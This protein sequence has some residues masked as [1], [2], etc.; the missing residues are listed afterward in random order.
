MINNTSLANFTNQYQLSKTLRFELKPV[1]RTAEWIEKHDIIGVKGDKLTGKDAKKAEHYKYAKRMLDAMHRIFIEDALGLIADEKL[2]NQLKNKFTELQ[3]QEEIKIDKDLQNIFKDILDVTANRW[4]AEYQQE[5][6]QFWREDIAEL[7]KKL[8]VEKDNQ[9]KKGFQSAIKAVQKKIDASDKVIK[10]NNIEVMYSNEDALTLLEWK[11]RSGVVQVTFKELE[12]A[13][14]NNPIPAYILCEYLRTFNKFYT[15]FAGFNENRQ[16]V[17]DLSGEKSTSIINR[18]IKDNLAFHF[19]NLKKWQTIRQSLAAAA[20]TFALKSFDPQ[21]LLTEIETNLNFSAESFFSIETFCESMNQSGIDCYNEIIGGRP[22]LDGGEKIQGI[23]EFINLCRQQADGK[24]QQFPPMQTLYKQILSKSDRTFIPEFSDDRDMLQAIENFHSYYFVKRD[25]HGQN[26]FTKFIDE[27]KQ[28]AT[29][30]AGEY[31]TIFLPADKISLISKLL[32]GHWNNLNE[33]LLEILGETDFNKRKVFSFAEIQEALD[34]GS[35]GE[36]FAIDEKFSK[37]NLIDCLALRFNEMSNAANAAWTELNNSGVLQLNKL[38]ANR[39]T[40]GDKGFEQIAAIKTFLDAA[41]ELAGF[42]RDWQ[43]NKE[44]LKMENRNRVWYNHIDDFVNKFQVIGVYNMVRNHITKKTATAEKLKINFENA[45]LLDGWDRNKEADNYGILLEKDNLFYL[46]IMTADSNR[47]FDYA[48]ITD[49]SAKK[50]EEKRERRKSLLASGNENSY[51]KMNYKQ[52]ASVGKDIFTLCWDNATNTAIRKTKDRESVWGEEI[53]RIKESKSYQNNESDRLTYFSYLLKCAQ[54]YWKHFNLDLKAAEGYDSLSDLL[55]NIANQ[56]YSISF[57]NVKKTYID[58]KVAT[59]ELYLFQIYSKDF[60]ATKKSGGRDNLH[61]IYWKALFAPENLEKTV[62]KLNGQA[63]IFFRQASIKYDA[64]IIR[65]GHHAE[66]LKGKFNYPIIKN[67]RFTENKFFF[68]CPIKLNFNAPNVPGRFNDHVREFLKNNPDINI[69]GIDRGEKHLLYY[70]VINQNGNILKQGSLNEISNGFVPRGETGE[71]AINYHAKLDEVE[72]K[73][74]LA[75]KSW[76]MIENIKELKAG[77]LSQ[78]VHKLAELIIRHNAIVVLEDL[79]WGFKRGRFK[80]E[81]QVYQKF[82]KALIDKLNYLVFKD[83]SDTTLPGHFLNAYQLTN[84]FES[85]QKMGKQSGILFYTTASYTSTTDPVTGFLK[86]VNPKYQKLEKSLE[87]WKSFDSIIYN[88]T[89]NRF[90]F[91]YTLGKI[92]SKNMHREKDEKDEQLKKRTW[93]VCSCVTR[94]R[95]VKTEKQTN[96]QKQ[97]T[98]AAQ[99]GNKGKHETFVVTD[100]IKKLLLDNNIDFARNANI[101]ASLTAK[102][103]V[104]FHKSMIYYFNAIMTMRVTDS[105]KTSGTNDNDFILSP[106][107]PFFDSRKTHPGLP[108]NGDANGAY[109]IARKGVCI[110]Q[111]INAADDVSKV[112]PA[113]SKQEWQNFCQNI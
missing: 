73:R 82:E 12:Q 22:A 30:L 24:R 100:E 79:N 49:D 4:I 95:Y 46:A 31:Q 90:E 88:P 39:T 72:K 26:T 80:V 9:R 34:E 98:S 103:D 78:V 110:L 54:S 21:T 60:S 43:E 13:D 65:A 20:E 2:L 94:S 44:I 28:L 23:N 89:E 38:D 48:A 56:G 18:S 67:K 14:N 102:N 104:A 36:R 105:D 97:N 7:E 1:G 3:N 33:E 59:G 40:P 81:K 112:N 37:H 17:Y 45:T 74:D 108:E 47:L 57:D 84:K 83:C 51:R 64:D 86:N 113:V 55:N 101:Q 58:E 42:V 63:E 8:A 29:D 70:S 52:I 91:T 16:N 96:E 69:I 25:E 99:I 61:T 68:H 32:T 71:R 15:Y 77:Y 6:P 66:K 92:A 27:T 107:E 109:N 62:L 53:T 75:R 11:I 19:A 50:I 85:F 87:F 76:S 111:K 93:T 5:M 41:I 10:K 106:V 35:R